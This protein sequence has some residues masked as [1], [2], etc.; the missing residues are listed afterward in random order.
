MTDTKTIRGAAAACG[1]LV[2]GAAGFLFGHGCGSVSNDR[3][4]AINQATTAACDRYQSCGLI[5]S[6]A[7]ASYAS[8]S[9]CQADWK[10]RFTTQWAPSC[11]GRI[12]HGM[13]NVCVEAID[14]TDCTSVVDVLSTF[15]VKC[16]MANVCDLHDAGTD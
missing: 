11:Q 10:A 15:Y 8:V 1:M 16:S 12:D 3:Q 6:A 13:L 7:G 2:L 14:S 5:S 4:D 9:D